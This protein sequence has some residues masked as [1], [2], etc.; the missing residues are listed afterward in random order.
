M[1]LNTDFLAKAKFKKIKSLI[2]KPASNSWKIGYLIG[3]G[4]LDSDSF[5]Y[6]EVIFYGFLGIPHKLDSKVGQFEDCQELKTKI[7]KMYN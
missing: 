7:Q 1:S 5:Y 6:L 3:Q 4:K 2:I